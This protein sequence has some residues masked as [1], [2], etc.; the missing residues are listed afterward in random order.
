MYRQCLWKCQNH[1]HADCPQIDLQ[2]KCN[3]NRKPSKF[4][5]CVC[6]LKNIIKFIMKGNGLKTVKTVQR[7]GGKNLLLQEVQE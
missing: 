7:Q 6:V 3:F 2:T 4:V 1:K 5:Q